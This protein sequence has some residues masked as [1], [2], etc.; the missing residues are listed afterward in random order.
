VLAAAAVCHNSDTPGTVVG[1]LGKGGLG[2]KAGKGANNKKRS[3]AIKAHE[4]DP[5]YV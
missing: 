5:R 3:N 2:G 1:L 4:S